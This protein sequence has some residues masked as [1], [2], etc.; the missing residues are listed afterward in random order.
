M[1]QEWYR[2]RL[3][4]EE[5]LDEG[6]IPAR[7]QGI[8]REDQSPPRAGTASLKLCIARQ[9]AVQLRHSLPNGA[10]ASSDACRRRTVAGA[11]GARRGVAATPGRLREASKSL[12]A[13]L[14]SGVPL[15]CG[16]ERNILFRRVLALVV[17]RDHVQ[18]VLVLALVFGLRD[19]SKRACV[20]L[21]VCSSSPLF[22]KGGVRRQSHQ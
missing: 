17:A 9:L 10:A 4:V 7:S 13:H 2:E 5:S 22:V 16:V 18:E 15:Q 6:N 21:L 12:V 19:N 1:P 8:C 11:P 14:A 3:A 20:F